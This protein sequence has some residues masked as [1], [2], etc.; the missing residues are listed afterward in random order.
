[1]AADRKT[2]RRQY[3]GVLKAQVLTECEAPGV[4]VTKVAMAHDINANI[5]HGWRQAQRESFQRNPPLYN[6]QAHF[7]PL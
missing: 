5:G 3:S 2:K 6:Q 1:M 4:L 7:V